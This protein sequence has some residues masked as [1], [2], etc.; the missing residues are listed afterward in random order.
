VDQASLDRAI[1]ENRALQSANDQLRNQLQ[2]QG[3]ELEELRGTVSEVRTAQL[4]SHRA[5]L[6]AEHP[7]AVAELIQGDSVDALNASVENA[8]TVYGRIAE[9]A[10][11][12]TAAA[13][14]PAGV[15]GAGAGGAAS[16]AAAGAAQADSP[17][18]RIQQGLNDAKWQRP[19]R[20]GS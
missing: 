4:E 5:R 19:P 11:S 9:G 8:K 17:M 15:P 18:G 7:D 20:Q 10:R 12:A 1:Q 3:T 2:E 6:I 14:V 16:G 13:T